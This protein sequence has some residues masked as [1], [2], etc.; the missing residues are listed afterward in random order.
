MPVMAPA[1]VA[2]TQNGQRGSFENASTSRMKAPPTKPTAKP[3]KAMYGTSA[4]DARSLGGTVK[5]VLL[6]STQRTSTVAVTVAMMTGTKPSTVYC[7]STTSMANIT[8]ASGVLKDAAIAAAAPHAVRVRR[9]SGRA[10]SAWASWLAA[11]LPKCTAGPSWPPE[12]PMFRAKTLPANWRP[13]APQPRRPW[14]SAKAV[15]S[16]AMPSAAACSSWRSGKRAAS[17]CLWAD[18]PRSCPRRRSRRRYP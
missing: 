13:A 12:S 15:N 11:A 8:P 2:C 6:P 18:Q 1:A 10:S 4:K 5:I 7:I 14:C 3:A 16:K 9:S 17:S